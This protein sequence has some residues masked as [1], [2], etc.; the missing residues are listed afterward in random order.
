MALSVHRSMPPAACFEEQAKV[1]LRGYKRQQFDVD[2][3]DKDHIEAYIILRGTK[4]RI[5]P[6]YFIKYLCTRSQSVSHGEST[7]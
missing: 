2:P 3:D 7:S 4:T 1:A 6:D 5:S